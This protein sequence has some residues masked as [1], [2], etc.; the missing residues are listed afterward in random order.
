MPTGGTGH[1]KVTGV[2]PDKD[3][4]DQPLKFIP[5]QNSHRKKAERGWVEL[6]RPRKS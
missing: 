5:R 2:V 1:G 3:I 6:T 4:F